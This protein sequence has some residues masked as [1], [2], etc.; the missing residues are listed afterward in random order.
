MSTLWYYAHDEK[1]LGPFSQTQL[2]EMAAAGTILPTDTVWL[3]GVVQGAQASRIKNL[4][5]HAVANP[6]QAICDV[7]PTAAAPVA[8]TP[9]AASPEM[10]VVNTTLV[11]LEK[12]AAPKPPP[13][14]PERP[15]GRAFALT[16]ADIEGQ[17]GTQFRYRK[18][19]IEC[20][21]KDSSSHTM[22][23]SNKTIKENFFCPKCRK[24]RDVA[25]QC[26][27]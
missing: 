16:G 6:V 14:K 12:P 17:D 1:K 20:G 19:C 18:K 9:P 7:P 25:I 21:Y 13:K 10:I 2:K 24:R 15:K 26:Q 23:I 4:F 3:K 8:S 22:V 27:A 5:P 11:P